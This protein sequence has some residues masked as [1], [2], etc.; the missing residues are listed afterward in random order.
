MK[1][2]IQPI[3]VKALNVIFYSSIV[4]FLLSAPWNTGWHMVGDAYS[5]GPYLPWLELIFPLSG[6]GLWGAFF[7]QWALGRLRP[8]HISRW[9]YL[10]L[11]SALLMVSVLFSLQ[12]D[13]SLGSLSIWLSASLALSLQLKSV[14]EAFW[15]WGVYGI[16]IILNFIIWYFYAP[17]INAE[18]LIVMAW[19]GALHQWQQKV[20]QGRKFMLASLILTLVTL[21]PLTP[22]VEWL[23]W[24]SFLIL[25]LAEFPLYRRKNTWLWA[26]V[27]ML[28]LLYAIMVLV[29]SGPLIN[30]E[31]SLIVSFNG[32]FSWWHGVGLGQFEWAQFQAQSLFLSPLEI[33]NQLPLWLRWWYENGI[34]TIALLPSLWLLTLAQKESFKFRFLLFWGTILLVPQ[35]WVSAGGIFIA[36]FWFFNH[37]SWEPANQLHEADSPN[38]L[39]PR[40]KRL[41]L[42]LHWTQG[43]RRGNAD[44]R[45]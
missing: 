12:P 14:L 36:S 30:G 28:L 5:L 44:K 18:L 19:F 11:F 9:F 31:S 39:T 35:L 3:I 21:L 23:I 40:V 17:F 42:K 45:R 2:W 15:F 37:H 6:L 43:R 8:I 38:V 22:G 26:G 16:A 33:V 4:L 24:G 27:L 1:N 20:S 7:S 13:S 32:L 25:W 41:G 10:L 29:K 34:L